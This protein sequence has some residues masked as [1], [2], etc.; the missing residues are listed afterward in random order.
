MREAG[1]LHVPNLKNQYMN[2]VNEQ[3]KNLRYDEPMSEHTSWQTGG[4][5]K[6][7]FIPES[8][9]QLQLFLQSLPD[10]EPILWLGLGSNVLVRDGG[11]NGTVI[12]TS[13][14]S[15]EIN[16]QDQTVTVDAG[17]PCPKLARACAKQGLIGI[18]FFAGIPGTV[19]GALAMNAG[20]FGGETW[21]F[22]ESVKTISI[23]GTVH[24]RVKTEFKTEYRSVTSNRNEWFLSGTFKLQHGDKDLALNKIKTFLAQRKATQ[25]M[26][27]PSCGSVFRNPDNDYAARLIE[28]CGLKGKQIGGATISTKHANFIVNTGNATSEDI[29]SLITIA[30][31]EVKQRFQIELIKEVKII[32]ESA[33]EKLN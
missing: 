27:L 14:L 15:N 8:V 19:G 4:T 18:E 25:P 17:V 9:E 2:T 10:N 11:F 30:S 16:I 21:D 12:S 32:G 23:D 26:G 20:A 31:N 1:Q 24:S 5:S 29:E 22:V 3:F 28:A 13:E 6:C 33:A 7:F